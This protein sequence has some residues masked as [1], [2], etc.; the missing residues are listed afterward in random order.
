MKIELIRIE[1]SMPNG[2]GGMDA[3]CLELIYDYLLQKYNQDMYRFI[4]I[5]QFE[6]DLNE[7]IMK[8]PEK[9]R[10][11]IN[12]HVPPPKDFNSRSFQQRN[13]FRLEVVHEALKRI[14]IHD[15]KLDILKLEMIRE[16]VLAKNFIFQIDYIRFRNPRNEQLLGKVVICPEDKRYIFY[17]VV[18]RDGV[19]ICKVQLFAGL[20][21]KLYFDKFFRSGKWKNENEI[22]IKGNSKEMEFRVLIN[23]CK[24]EII[25]NTAYPKPP[26]F[27][28]MR[29]DITKEEKDKANKDWIHSLP[30]WL[31]GIADN[32]FN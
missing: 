27:E 2:I 20:P 6:K 23:E 12:I 11:H 16:E 24:A 30:P 28:M 29:A 21:G 25:N 17:A 3:G 22:V 14:A 18:E 13:I 4:L 9:A 31:G 26:L 15:K 1:S 10:L 5:H 8:G 19:E 32:K 7:L